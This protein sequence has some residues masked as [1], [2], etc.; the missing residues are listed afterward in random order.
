MRKVLIITFIITD[1]LGELVLICGGHCCYQVGCC[2]H[3]FDYSLLVC[4]Y[5]HHCVHTP[6]HHCHHVHVGCY[7]I[8]VITAV[9]IPVIIT[10]M[11]MVIAHMSI[12]V[13]L[14]ATERMGL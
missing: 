6:C 14:E 1:E 13:N 7:L 8:S 9:F 4:L 10:I 11:V 3:E 5:Y 12:L 2:H